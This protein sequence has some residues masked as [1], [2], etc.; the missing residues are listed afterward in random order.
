M[1]STH[2]QQSTH[3]QASGDSTEQLNHHI[4]RLALVELKTQLLKGGVSALS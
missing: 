1:S 3:K 4:A 2:S